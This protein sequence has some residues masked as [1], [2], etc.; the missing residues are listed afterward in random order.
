MH[1]SSLFRLLCASAFG[2]LAAGC[3]G[4]QP[5]TPSL[6]TPPVV[7]APAQTTPPPTSTSPAYA[8]ALSVTTS[9]PVVGSDTM[10]TY[11]I[12]PRSNAPTAA[13]A[14]VDF[15][16]ATTRT[17]DV[18]TLTAQVAHVYR[19]ANKFTATFRLVDRTGASYT[20]ESVAIVSDQPPPPPPSPQSAPV[21][22]YSVVLVASPSSVFTGGSSTLTA[23]VTA[24]NG[25]P[26]TPSSF[27]WDCTNDGTVDF[28]TASTSQACSYPTAGTITAKVTVSN[29][30]AGGTG[31]TTVTVTTPPPPTVT[32]N[33]STGAK[34]VPPNPSTC[35]ASATVNG[36]L[37]PS[38]RITQVV[39]TFGDGTPDET[40]LSNTSAPHQYLSSNTFTVF[41]T[42]TISGVSGTVTGSTTT[43]VAP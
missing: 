43:T 42:A 29:G 33:C 37:V 35:V 20:A 27:A 31:T 40:S 19:S 41:G 21:P 12:T 17:I 18:G 4:I 1:S 23:T 26:A 5:N 36:V 15:G 11:T 38:S 6:V 8:L 14:T 30:A 3:H 25:A 7:T 16:D 28:T 10:F 13:S 22:F 34:V 9:T 39:W 24:N 32:L 2:L